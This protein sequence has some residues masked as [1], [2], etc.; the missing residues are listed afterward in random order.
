[1]NYKERMDKEWEEK[2]KFIYDIKFCK[3]LLDNLQEDYESPALYR[4]FNKSIALERGMKEVKNNIF[5]F[6]STNL[7][8]AQ[9]NLRKKEVFKVNEDNYVEYE[10]FILDSYEATL[11]ITERAEYGRT[12]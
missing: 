2:T 11:D 7:K 3:M 5:K 4:S 8:K 1:M 6:S 9:E 12:I 10:K